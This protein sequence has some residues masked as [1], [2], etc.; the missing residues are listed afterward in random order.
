[1]GYKYVVCTLYYD[2]QAPN[3]ILL[4]FKSYVNSPLA[5]SDDGS[6]ER[7]EQYTWASRNVRK[8]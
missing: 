5:L 4:T 6:V 3:V 8:R 1:M 7:P 2:G